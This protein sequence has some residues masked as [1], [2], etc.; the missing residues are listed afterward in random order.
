MEKETASNMLGVFPVRFSEPLLPEETKKAEIGKVVIEK[1][2]DNSITIQ[3]KDIF[4]ITS[5]MASLF[6]GRTF[7][8]AKVQPSMKA[9]FFARVFK[10][11]PSEMQLIMEEGNPLLV[12]PFKRIVKNK[13]MWSRILELS[14]NYE[15]T[16]KALEI[17]RF[18]FII[19]NHAAF[20]DD[21]GIDFSNASKDYV[22]MLPKYPCKTARK[23]RE[24]LKELTGKDCAVIITDTV[25]LLGRIGSQDIAI[26]YSG[27]D[28]VTRKSGSK[29]IFGKCHL[30]GNDCVIDSLA[31]IAGMMMGQ[32]DELT[33]MTLIRGYDYVEEK[34]NNEMCMKLLTYPEGT[35]FRSVF[36]SLTTTIWYHFL[37]IITFWM[38]KG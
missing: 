32:M 7:Q 16:E 28:P 38:P 19:N 21:A 29:D 9:R 12:L 13:K 4:V 30:G 36:L 15:G 1:L 14:A 5:K 3:N 18:V 27:I 11:D 33:P 37:N 8:I 35:T 25:S 26:G 34:E 23:I 6:E 22:T 17:S 31:G 10:K 24:S 2:K 20:L